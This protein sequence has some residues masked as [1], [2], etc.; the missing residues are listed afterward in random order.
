MRS[1]VC[2]GTDSGGV[3]VNVDRII[4]VEDTEDVY[5]CIV[6]IDGFKNPIWCNQGT[7]NLIEAI[8]DVQLHDARNMP[9]HIEG[10]VGTISE[11]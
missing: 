10:T 2:I 1:F 3:Y 9:V 5:K 6:T 11:D 4:S 8:Y 7:D